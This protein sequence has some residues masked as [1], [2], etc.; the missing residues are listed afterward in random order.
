MAAISTY[1]TKIERWTGCLATPP[2]HESWKFTEKALKVATKGV[3]WLLNNQAM[4]SHLTPRRLETLKEKGWTI[5]HLHI[6]AD[7]RWFGRYLFV[8]LE[9]DTQKD[10]KITWNTKTY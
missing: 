1:G 4:N 10:C 8:I 7:R 9:K 3:A 6:V 5:T 2:Y